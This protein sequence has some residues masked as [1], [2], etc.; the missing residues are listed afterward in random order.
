V[1]RIEGADAPNARNQFIEDMKAQGIAC[2]IHFRAVHEQK[3]YREQLVGN[4]PNLPNTTWNS[5]RIC[6]LPLFPD[7]SLADVERVVTAMRNV[8]NSK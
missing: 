5:A 3:F 1:V 8:L 2:G 7:M 6:S 4:A